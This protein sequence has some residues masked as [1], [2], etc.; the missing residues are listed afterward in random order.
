MIKKL[1]T[2]ITCAFLMASGFW[3]IACSEP[4]DISV[5]AISPCVIVVDAN[6]NASQ[7]CVTEGSPITVKCL[8]CGSD[9]TLQLFQSGT[10]YC[11]KCSESDSSEEFE[12][13]KVKFD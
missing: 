6:S 4:K 3:L 11:K 1:L 9:E 13:F 2:R 5:R 10:I 12:L 8:H 7:I